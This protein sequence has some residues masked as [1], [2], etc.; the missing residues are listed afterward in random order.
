[1]IENLKKQIEFI[2]EIDKVKSIFRKTKLFDKSRHENDAEH[3]WHLA[4]M[5][6]T[7]SEYSNEAI[8]IAKV[9][10]MVLIHDIV[11]IDAGDYIVYTDQTLEKAQKEIE[12]ANRIFGI[13][14]EKQKNEFI[15]LWKDRNLLS[16]Y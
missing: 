1:M 8:D 11:E 15:E 13:L 3:S 14:P 4:V 7:L 9:I 16:L 2:I 6:I 5:A 12:A 10:K